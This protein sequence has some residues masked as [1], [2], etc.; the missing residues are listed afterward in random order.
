M[1][2][3]CVACWNALNGT[4]TPEEAYVLSRDLELCEGCGKWKQ[5]I[6][7]KR[8]HYFIRELLGNLKR[9]EKK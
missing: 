8:K 7:A 3:F 5:V 1:A 4:N 2:E 9:K 6:I